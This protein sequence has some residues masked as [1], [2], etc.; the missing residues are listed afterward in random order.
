M[1]GHIEI[2]VDGIAEPN[3]GH[4]CWAWLAK[5][6]G[7]VV[8]QDSGY[9]G[10]KITNNVAEYFAA[11]HAL[12]WLCDQPEE[13]I[14]DFYSDS[15]LVLNQISGDWACNK[16]DLRKLRDRCRKL[17]KGLSINLA[18][19]PGAEN[20]ADELAREAYRTHVGK[21][22]PQRHAGARAAIYREAIDR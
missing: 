11:G 15:Q 7:R 3:P 13:F 5:I 22:P 19:I 21:E 4:A 14:V 18:W 17:M 1:A 8:G 10:P 6:D 16:D 12:K 2:Y 20:P 9:I